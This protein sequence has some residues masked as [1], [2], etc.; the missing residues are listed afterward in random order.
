MNLGDRTRQSSQ[1]L[2]TRIALNYAMSGVPFWRGGAFDFTGLP[3][4]DTELKTRMMPYT[5][6]Y[7]HQA[8]ATGLPIMRPMVLEY[9]DD[10][11]THDLDSQ[12]LYGEE[13]LI[14]P[15]I[16]G[17]KSPQATSLEEGE[18]WVRVYIP[19]GEW[20]DY[21][22]DDRYIGPGWK[23]LKATP[24]QEPTLV[25]GGAIIPMGPMME[26]IGEK[27]NNPLTLDV[28]PDGASRFVMYEDDGETYAYESGAYSTT[29]FTCREEK[30]GVEI[31]IGPAEGHYEGMLESRDYR[32][33]LHG[34]T[35]P[36]SITVNGREVV[37]LGS[38]DEWQEADSGWR[39][40]K[41]GVFSIHGGGP[42]VVHVK[43]P[44]VKRSERVRIN[45]EGAA[46]IRYYFNM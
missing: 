8:Q 40:E 41:G 28:Y 42:F 29:E 38:E 6:S 9:Q 39:V 18:A 37:K 20:I 31:G 15:V 45:L 44:T 30:A 27:P 17:L 14:A 24:G 13:F 35:E 46:P 33:R 3:L 26:Y 32:L 43:L 11:E 1:R 4:T 36:R 34:I 19:E 25:R 16:D 23:H 22:N 2:R 10:P 12:F 5:Y 7:W 21:W